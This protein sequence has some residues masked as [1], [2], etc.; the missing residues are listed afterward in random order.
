[1][2]GLSA[3][4]YHK[5]TLIC[6]LFSLFQFGIYVRL[7]SSFNYMVKVWVIPLIHGPLT[8]IPSTYIFIYIFFAVVEMGVDVF[9]L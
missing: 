5:R 7:D 4:N 1:M 3:K 9:I 8:L 6:F 2:R